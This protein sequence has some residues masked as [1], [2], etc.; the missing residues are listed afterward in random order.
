[1]ISIATLFTTLVMLL[2]FANTPGITEVQRQE[3]L[4]MADSLQ[5]YIIN[6]SVNM[7]KENKETKKQAVKEVKKLKADKASLKEQKVADE[8]KQAKNDTQGDEVK[9]SIESKRVI[10]DIQKKSFKV[11]PSG[12]PPFAQP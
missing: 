2:N 9:E 1:M 7:E 6:Y 4:V 11:Y 12:T 10:T 8:A 5:A 3:V